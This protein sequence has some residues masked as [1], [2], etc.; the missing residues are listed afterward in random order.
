[1]YFDCNL[2]LLRLIVLKVFQKLHKY[3]FIRNIQITKKKEKINCCTFLKSLLKNMCKND[4]L[5]NNR[6]KRNPF[7]HFL[8]NINKY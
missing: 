3:F 1:M 6:S 4:K 8:K 2:T 7:K 5:A